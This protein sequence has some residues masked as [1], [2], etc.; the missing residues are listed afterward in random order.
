MTAVEA[1]DANAATGE[2]EEGLTP[3]RAEADDEDL[4]GDIGSHPPIVPPSAADL[5]SGAAHAG[6]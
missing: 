5:K 4:G 6:V 1:D 2:F 3:H